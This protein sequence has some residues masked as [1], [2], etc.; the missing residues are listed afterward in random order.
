MLTL[1]PI[2]TAVESSHADKIKQT[3][4]SERFANGRLLYKTQPSTFINPN[5]IIDESQRIQ[6]ACFKG[7]ILFSILK[8]NCKNSRILMAIIDQSS[9]FSS[10][11]KSLMESF[12]IHAY[13][14]NINENFYSIE[15]FI[16]N[17]FK[18][19]ELRNDSK[20]VTNDYERWLINLSM[21]SLGAKTPPKIQKNIPNEINE[22][23]QRFVYDKGKKYNFYHEVAM[24]S[25][26]N[27]NPLEVKDVEI[28]LEYANKAR[29][30]LLITGPSPSYV[31]F[32]V[33]EYDGIY[34]DKPAGKVKDDKKDAILAAACVPIIRVS[35]KD[36][37]NLE[38]N[39]IIHISEK[40]K[41][42][43]KEWILGRLIAYSIEA[44]KLIKINHV[45]RYVKYNSKVKKLFDL[46]LEEAMKINSSIYL[47]D[48]ERRKVFADCEESL[49]AEND[50][51][52]DDLLLDKYEF[53]G[54]RDMEMNSLMELKKY[55]S[56]LSDYEYSSDNR[57]M[58]CSA[59][60]NYGDIKKK[61]YSVEVY[62][63][64]SG[65]EF[66]DFE[67]V[68]K[69]E[70]K[71]SIVVQALLWLDENHIANQLLL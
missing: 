30:D 15:E 8:G 68:I 12:G 6:E 58:A 44:V 9:E 46:K 19:I 13:L 70:L 65:L 28:D 62:F 16:H 48:E 2:L 18:N 20:R 71:Y 34:H 21:T 51:L 14:G 37:P 43:I 69:D 17:S 23:F 64:G 25:F 29:L 53:D 47:S 67:Q 45:E 60:L 41:S 52:Y 11:V 36:G 38:K 40:K 31:P 56:S 61:I 33:V 22:L 35:Y 50:Q 1:I 4:K 55:N 42:E 5:W 7:I 3:L 27:F 63:R 49:S 59:M 24:K 39:S 54:I 57:G 32:L 10:E 66:F 26:I